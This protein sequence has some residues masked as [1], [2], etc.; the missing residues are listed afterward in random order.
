MTR[1][2]TKASAVKV[3]LPVML[4]LVICLLVLIPVLQ[5]KNS[6]T[7]HDE[8]YAKPLAGDLGPWL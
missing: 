2:S 8:D 5:Q 4:L 6:V 3:L 7:P 1:V